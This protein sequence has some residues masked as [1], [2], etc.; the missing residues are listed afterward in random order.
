MTA[1]NLLASNDV[2]MAQ[3]HKTAKNVLARNKVGMEPNHM[4]AKKGSIAINEVGMGPNHMTAK[5]SLARNGVGMEP[6]HMTAKNVLAINEVGMEP[7]HTKEKNQPKRLYKYKERHAKRK[8]KNWKYNIVLYEFTL[9]PQNSLSRYTFSV[10]LFDL[11]QRL[12]LK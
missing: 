8:P 10:F 12:N 5:K 1:K 7:N 11:D 6:N 3:Y 9:L 2:W 4:T